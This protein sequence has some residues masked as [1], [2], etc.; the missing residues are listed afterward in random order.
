MTSSASDNAVLGA[1]NS[2]AQTL[3][4]VVR[5]AGPFLSGGLFSLST[6]VKP[7]GEALPFGV[8][9]IVSFL[10]FLLSFGVQARFLEGDDNDDDDNSKSGDETLQNS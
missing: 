5:A 2:L 7:K 3:S 1:L 6:N 4:A 10:G 8:F 9:A